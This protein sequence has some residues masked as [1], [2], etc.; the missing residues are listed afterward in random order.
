MLVMG[1][2]EIRRLSQDEGMKD[3][4]IAVMLGIHRVTVTRIR[5]RY[6]IP[7]ANLK[8]RK[9]KLVCCTK[10]RASFI[11]RRWERAHRCKACSDEMCQN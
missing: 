2:E 9:D 1:V 4:E 7:K 8:N 11:I 6:S 3:S 10:C 5:H